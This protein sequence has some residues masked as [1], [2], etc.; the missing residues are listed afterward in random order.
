M[1]RSRAR[2]SFDEFRKAL[3]DEKSQLLWERRQSGPL[4]PIGGGDSAD[5]AAAFQEQFVTLHRSDF[6]TSKIRLIDAALARL[7]AG[8]FGR[9]LEC[10]GLIAPARLR[11]VPWASYCVTCQQQHD[12]RGEADRARVA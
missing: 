9:C 6:Q 2:G 5:Q 12:M 3:L 1:P 8:E 11:A 10:D 7:D 4:A